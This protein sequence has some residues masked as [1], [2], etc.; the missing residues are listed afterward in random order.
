M[1]KPPCPDKNGQGRE[2]KFSLKGKW[3]L[4]VLGLLPVSCN[5]ISECLPL[6]ASVPAKT[7]ACCPAGCDWWTVFR[8]PGLN[9]LMAQMKMGNYQFQSIAADWQADHRQR[10]KY[11]VGGEE[12]EI[13]LGEEMGKL[14]LALSSQLAQQY[15]SLRF[16]D[17]EKRILHE[18]LAT[19]EDN[20]RL[21]TERYDTGI[22]SEFDVEKATIDVASTKADLSRMN[23]PRDQLENAI[24]LLVGCDPESF[25]IPVRS[26]ESR[27][28]VLRCE[29]PFSILGNRPDVAAAVV[30]LQTAN[31][32]AGL[33]YRD[34]FPCG[35]FISCG[36][37][38][39]MNSSGFQKWSCENFALC[40]DSTIH[41]KRKNAQRKALVDYQKAMVEAFREVGDALAELES[42]GSEKVAQETLIRAA[43]QTESLI[44]EQYEEGVVSFSDVAE[45]SRGRMAAQRRL[46]QIRS[47]Q[48][49]AMVKLI[50]ALGG[51]CADQYF[52]AE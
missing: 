36:N 16:I 3:L 41:E 34:Y 2:G 17:E 52:A 45:S 43:R 23:M 1:A 29:V 18:G 12:A 11:A 20:L 19:W 21:A 22:T 48:Y 6:S 24:A 37:S 14:R 10:L 51:K 33:E 42:L 38:S 50:T 28:P 44:K 5:T 27:M 40:S 13:I 15:F 7:G 25:Q 31:C 39:K 30:R 47:K 26:I 32:K 9:R 49:V 35:S 46:V 8:D 4:F